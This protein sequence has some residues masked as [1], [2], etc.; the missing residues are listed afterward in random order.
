MLRV[1]G[2]DAALAAGNALVA[3]ADVGNHL[4]AELVVGLELHL[5]GLSQALRL[6]ENLRLALLGRLERIQLL[7]LRLRPLLQL[8]QIRLRHHEHLQRRTHALACSC[9]LVSSMLFFSATSR[10]RSSLVCAISARRS[11]NRGSHG[12]PISTRTNRKS[13]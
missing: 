7:A 11:A 5:A 1:L 6:L 8:V 9:D 12:R 3:L 10:S 2:I 4:V 13:V